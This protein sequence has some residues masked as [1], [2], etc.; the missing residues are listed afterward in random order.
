MPTGRH[1]PR[2]AARIREAA[3]LYCDQCGAL[4]RGPAGSD[5]TKVAEARQD[6]AYADPRAARRASIPRQS[7]APPC[8]VPAAPPDAPV[9]LEVNDARFYVEGCVGPI[10]LRLT[11][12]SPLPIELVELTVCSQRLGRIRRQIGSLAPGQTRRQ[13]IEIE[14]QKAG[15]H[16]AD[17]RVSLRR[18]GNVQ[19]WVTQ[20][21]FRVLQRHL[22][23]QSLTVHIDQ[24]THMSGERIGFGQ[25]VRKEVE[26]GVL[27]G[28]IRDTNDLLTQSFTPS[29]RKLPLAPADPPLRPVALPGAAPLRR[30]T[31]RRQVR[32]QEAR[33]LVVGTHPVRLGRHRSNDIVLRVLPRS[34]AHDLLTR[35]IQGRAPHL[36]LE[37]TRDGLFVR[38]H[39]TRNGTWLDG[40]PVLDLQPIP[41]DRPCTLDVARALHLRLT[42]LRDPGEPPAMTRYA[43][44]GPHDSLW[45]HSLAT[46]LRGLRIERVHNLADRECYLVVFRWIDLPQDLAGGWAWFWKAGPSLRIVRAAGRLWIENRDRSRLVRVA[47]LGCDR[48]TLVPA[49]ANQRIAAGVWAV[50]CSEARQF[51]LKPPH[52]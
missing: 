49:P 38:D 10:E 26:A 2:C 9:L 37:L 22:S 52:R 40:R 12:R 48:K 51:A 7:A 35:R 27:R 8:A 34:E 46:G 18:G 14:P 25:S 6:A 39:R 50:D 16:V 13:F 47:D 24:S 15:E 3:A 36:S 20:V 29:W 4:L 42:P 1:C 43:A 28:L 30:L 41:L 19:N 31:L 33:L 11:N 32:G 17:I 23:P 21:V 45:E 5:P 44:L